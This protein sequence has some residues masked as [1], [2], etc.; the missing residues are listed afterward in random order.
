MGTGGAVLNAMVRE[1]SRERR[2]KKFATIV[3]LKNFNHA[4]KLILNHGKKPNNNVSGIRL[5]AEGKGP[6][7][8]TKIIK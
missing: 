7:I 4:I 5:L 3:T 1:E 6:E 8:V 2:V